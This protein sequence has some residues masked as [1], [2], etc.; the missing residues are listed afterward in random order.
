[1]MKPRSLF[2]I[3]AALLFLCASISE[4]AAQDK[5]P[6]KQENY[7]YTFTDD[8]LDASNSNATGAML[9]VR[10]PGRRDRLLRPR[11]HFIPEMLKSVES[12]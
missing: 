5:T 7:S 10:Q 2:S 3:T 1:M 11:L 8:L 9:Q 4:A 6:A 12:M